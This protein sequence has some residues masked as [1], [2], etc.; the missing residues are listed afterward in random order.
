MEARYLPQIRRRSRHGLRVPRLPF[1]FED[2]FRSRHENAYQVERAD[3]DQMLLDHAP[4][5]R[6]RGCRGDHGRSAWSLRR[7]AAWRLNVSNAA[8]ARVVR[9]RYRDRLQR[10]ATRSLAS[11]ST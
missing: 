1:F 11:S 4:G 3:F 6:R 9:A 8:G 7:G 2:G 5:Q 10:A